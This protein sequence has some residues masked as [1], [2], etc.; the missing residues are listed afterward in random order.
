MNWSACTV[1]FGWLNEPTE[2]TTNVTLYKIVVNLFIFLKHQIQRNHRMR[3][4][5]AKILFFASIFCTH[6]LPE[7]W[8]RIKSQRICASFRFLSEMLQFWTECRNIWEKAWWCQQIE[9][10]SKSIDPL[11]SM[12]DLP[13]ILPI[14]SSPKYPSGVRWSQGKLNKNIIH[15]R[16]HFMNSD[17]R[18][19]KI[20]WLALY[21]GDDS[22]RTHLWR[23]NKT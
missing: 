5:N 11:A 10:K 17:G 16:F 12:L 21:D 14:N 15:F 7:I 3:F 4:K 13:M 9:I 18:F 2:S 8:K 1:R 23:S 6:S 20:T 22:H 19:N